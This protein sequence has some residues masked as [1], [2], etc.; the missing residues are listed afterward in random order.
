M[1]ADDEVLALLT[2]EERCD[3]VASSGHSHEHRLLRTIATERK[4]ANELEAGSLNYRNQVIEAAI[5]RANE[6]EADLKRTQAA[7]VE[8]CQGCYEAATGRKRED[9]N[10]VLNRQYVIDHVVVLAARAAACARKEFEAE[11][12][13][14]VLEAELDAAV[15]RNIAI[16]LLR[17]EECEERIQIADWHHRVADVITARSDAEE[18]KGDTCVYAHGVLEEVLDKIRD[19]PGW[20]GSEACWPSAYMDRESAAKYLEEVKC[21]EPTVEQALKWAAHQLR[22]GADHH[23]RMAIF[24]KMRA[25][26]WMR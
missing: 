17:E 24:K 6:A 10:I 13:A 23:A 26:G 21:V 4:R 14:M 1:M 7:L 25:E 19:L 2:A 18:K 16:Q 12:R 15:K 5:S 11:Q 3:W 20:N 22:S 8:V 9:G